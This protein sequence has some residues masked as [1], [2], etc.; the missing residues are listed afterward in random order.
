MT[1]KP[2]HDPGLGDAYQRI[3]KSLVS[4]PTL[5][6]GVSSID[7]QLALPNGR[8]KQLYPLLEAEADG[9]A[10][11]LIGPRFLDVLGIRYI[12]MTQQ[13]TT[14]GFELFSQDGPGGLRIYRNLFA[15]P[16]LQL[17]GEAEVVA[18]AQAAMQGMREAARRV[19]FLE[20]TLSGA[21]PKVRSIC[22]AKRLA[23]TPLQISVASATQY[24]LAVDLPCDAWL[25]VADANYPG[26]RAT[27][28]G[29]RQAVYTAQVLGK[30]IQLRAGHNQISIDYVPRAFYLGAAITALAVLVLL[31][32]ATLAIKRRQ[33]ARA[34]ISCSDQPAFGGS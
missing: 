6:W 1:F 8:W 30:S 2:P 33:A 16:R 32:L 24:R 25:F 34:A 26:W 27:V 10:A 9:R 13:V 28:N 3:L 7:G 15:Q 20:A 12:S 4:F 21:T 19:L 17:Y 23:R 31:S 5:E 18:D 11:K 29:V 14:S 22:A